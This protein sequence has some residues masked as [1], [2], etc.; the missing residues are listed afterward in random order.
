MLT[1]VHL[2][3]YIVAEGTAIERGVPADEQC[4]NAFYEALYPD[5]VVPDMP[6]SPEE[7]ALARALLPDFCGRG[8]A[9]QIRE[10]G[11]EAIGGCP[12]G[13]VYGYMG[14]RVWLPGNPFDPP[15]RFVFN[16]LQIGPGI[17]PHLF[18]CL[19]IFDPGTDVLAVE[20][21]VMTPT[22]GKSPH[23]TGLAGLDTW[24]W[25]DFSDPDSHSIE[26]TTVIEKIQGLPI[27]IAGRAWVDKIEWDMDGDG[28]WD[29]TLDI[30]D[31]W[32]EPASHDTYVALGGADGA[33]VAA[34]TFLYETKGDYQV[35]VGV[36]WRGTYT[37]I[38]PGFGGLY[39][40]PAITRVEAFP[41]QVCEVRAVLVNPSDD[42]TLPSSCV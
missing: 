13:T 21:S 34:G 18:E 12:P 23:V 33:D 4:W 36:T 32:D 16:S 3:N 41:Y 9:F 26:L 25:F 5:G 20:D 42:R 40:Y 7:I 30:P 35:R 8:L 19:E 28:N 6:P 24:L 14:T 27:T 38:V 15:G 11:P 17:D 10:P 37:V 2:G 22:F 39:V 1:P 29:V 31:S